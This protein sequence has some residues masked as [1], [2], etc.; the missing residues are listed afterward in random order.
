MLWLTYFSYSLGWIRSHDERASTFSYRKKRRMNCQRKPDWTRIDAFMKEGIWTSLY[1]KRRLKPGSSL[2]NFPLHPG[3]DGDPW[4]LLTRFIVLIFVPIANH[5]CGFIPLF[6]G[7][8]CPTKNLASPTKLDVY[9]VE[10]Q[11]KSPKVEGMPQGYLSS[12]LR[13]SVSK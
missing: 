12:L 3:R 2:P 5:L 9:L 4:C 10:K 8:W 13:K 1:Q 7:T 6:K 11:I